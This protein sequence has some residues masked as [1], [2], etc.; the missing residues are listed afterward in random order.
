MC[1]QRRTQ[2]SE[3]LRS[4]CASAQSNQSPRYAALG[5]CSQGSNV[6]MDKKNMIRPN[7]MNAQADVYDLFVCLFDLS[8]YVPSTIFQLYRDGSSWVE[9]V[10][11]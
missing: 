7:R 5:T 3:G 8:L 9:P 10:L 2:I 4:A 6:F 1:D 11:S